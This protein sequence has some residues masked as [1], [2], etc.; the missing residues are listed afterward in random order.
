MPQIE[1]FVI[2][3]PGTV[4]PSGSLFTPSGSIGPAGLNAFSTSTASFTVPAIGA[5]ANL[6]VTDASSFLVGE[7]VYL[8]Q[9]GGGVGLPGI[10]QVTAKAGNTLTLLNPTPP[11]AVPNASTTAAGLLAQ[12]SGN[13]T[14]Y[15]RAD[16]TSQN[17][18]TAVQPAIWSARLRSYNSVGNPN[19][20]IDQR[21]CGTGTT[22]SAFALDRWLVS[23]NVATGTC[24]FVQN[25]VSGAAAS[26]VVPGTNFGITNYFLRITVTTQQASLLAG[27]YFYIYQNIEGPLRQLGGDPHTM[28]ILCRS[29][30]A[31]LSFGLSMRDSS[32]THSLVS[33]CTIPTANTWTLIQLPNLPVLPAG[34]STY[35]YAPGNVAYYFT[36]APIVGS[37]MTTPANGVWQNGNF[38]GALGQSN[39]L[40]SPV[41]STLDIAFC[42]HEPLSQPSQLMDIDFVTNLDR[43]LRYYTKSYVYGA[44]AG[45]VTGQGEINLY[46]QASGNPWTYIAF[47]KTMAKMPSITCWNPVTASSNTVRNWTGSADLAITGAQ[48]PSDAGFS[49]F[50]LS[51]PPASAYRSLNHYVADT[52]W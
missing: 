48:D 30:V 10:L 28:Q 23:K 32:I 38:T 34:W 42:Q 14:D 15:I 40:A 52:G 45:A 27:D 16:N 1:P 39:F 12:V 37:T 7:L 5:T 24:S 8:D 13:T 19:F 50:T 11:P 3:S 46:N 31:G 29:S 51:A 35:Q 41:N 25:V 26:I 43:C 22:T 17:L 47:K 44:V 4:I 33:L 9:A 36:I 20:E 21:T 6:T 49:N 18:A 2:P